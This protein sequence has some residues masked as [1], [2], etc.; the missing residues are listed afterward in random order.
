M[1]MQYKS[2]ICY[3]TT[4]ISTTPKCK[5]IYLCTCACFNIVIVHHC[6]T[7]T[8][9]HIHYNTYCMHKNSLWLA[10]VPSPVANNICA[11]YRQVLTLYKILQAIIHCKK[12]KKKTCWPALQ[13]WKA[14]NFLS[15]AA[16]Y[17]G[18]QWL[19]RHYHNVFGT[20][21]L[22]TTKQHKAHS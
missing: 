18:R 20:T 21:W 14:A 7:C 4:S 13:T 17:I 1:C 5:Q 6:S 16:N 19:C 12:N 11:Q 2:P 15:S 22:A 10:Q 8:G 3:A 9:L